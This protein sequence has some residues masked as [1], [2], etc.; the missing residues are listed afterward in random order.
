[1]DITERKAAEAQIAY[2]AY[3]D[4]LTG[5]SNRAMFDELLET[6]NWPGMLLSTGARPRGRVL[7]LTTAPL[8]P[9]GTG[10]GSSDFAYWKSALSVP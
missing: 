6:P 9:A 10:V 2:L 5:L 8:M 1:L 4:K 3:H 7:P